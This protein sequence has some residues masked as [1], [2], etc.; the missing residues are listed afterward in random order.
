MILAILFYGIAFVFLIWTCY[1]KGREKLTIFAK[2]VTSFGFLLI[3]LV[4]YFISRDVRY[5]WIVFPGLLFC[6]AGDILL[7]IRYQKIEQKWLVFGI[8]S[9]LMAHIYFI[10]RLQEIMPIHLFEVAISIAAMG[11]VYGIFKLPFMKPGA[12]KWLC[13][14]YSFFV[15]M[16]LIKGVQAGAYFAYRPRGIALLIGAIFFWTSDF[17]LIFQYFS[18]KEIKSLRFWNLLMYYIGVAGIASSIQFL[19]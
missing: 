18:E 1:K 8:L 9:F 15:T 17:T 19:N 12:V 11:M 14:F 4:G 2:T 13:V 7:A 16:L 10:F 5:F 3:S 6:F